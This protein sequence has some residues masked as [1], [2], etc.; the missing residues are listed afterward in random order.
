[1]KRIGDVGNNQTDRARLTRCQPT[2]YPRRLKTCL[3]DDLLDALACLRTDTFRA[4]IEHPGYGGFGNTGFLGDIGDGD[5]QFGL[6]V[7]IRVTDLLNRLLNDMV[8]IQ[9]QQEHF[10]ESFLWL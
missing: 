2:R 8:S 4:I 3:A 7:A 5:F 9:T 1:M 6:V 10:K